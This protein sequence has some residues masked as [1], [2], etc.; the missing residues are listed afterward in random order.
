MKLKT[1]FATLLIT[2]L[3]VP[4]ISCDDD[5]GASSDSS[6]TDSV[7]TVSI[8]L[9]KT[10]L[11]IMA[12]E[13][14]TISATISSD[15]EV[16]L[17]WTSSDESIATVS[18]GTITGIGNGWVDIVAT[19]GT[20]KA[21][22][23]VYVQDYVLVWS[24]EFE[25][26]SLN[27]DDWNYEIGNGSWGWGNGESE[28]YTSEESNIRIEDGCLVIE[29]R[30]ETIDDYEYTSARITTEDKQYFTYGKIEARIKLPS[31]GGTW[32]AFWML[33][34]SGG[35]P[36]GGEIDIME[37]VGNSPDMISYATH[38][39]NKNGNLGNNWNSQKTISGVE[40]EFH[41]FA[42]EWE[43]DYLYGR[44]AITFSVDGDYAAVTT[45]A[46][47]EEDIDSWPFY[48]DF[49][50]ILNL[51]LGGSMGGTIDDTIFDNQ[52]TD[53][54]VMLVDYVRVYQIQ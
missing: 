4:L 15:S 5:D 34:Q 1:A 50:I 30:K 48:K 29:A 7:S 51:A 8:T 18:D 11:V 54:V 45:Q 10:A 24:D 53:P 35:W 44:D 32:P 22:C 41:V 2:A 13:S 33:A 16:T 43:S 3:T 31:G 52:D 21:T 38:T 39:T 27:T 47:D 49:Y 28:Y 46:S 40:D 6:A 17:E 36:K 9:S 19:A 25:A 12:G 37:H 14:E 20:A 26:S 42:I 23:S